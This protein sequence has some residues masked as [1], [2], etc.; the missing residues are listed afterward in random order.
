MPLIVEGEILGVLDVQSTEIGAFGPDD[1]FILETLADQVAVAVSS[2]RAYE[3]Q[4]E[5]AWVTTVMLQVAEAT[6]RAE[7]MADALDATVRVTAMLAG[8]ASCIIWLWNEERAAFEYGASYG[9]RFEQ[10]ED[11]ATALRLLPGEWSALD[12]LRLEQKPAVMQRGDFRLPEP[13]HRIC[14]GDIVAL[15]PMLNRGETFGILGVSFNRELEARLTERRVTM[16]TGIAQ[17][18]AAAV[19]N[20]RL[21]AAREEEAWLST[22]LLQV[23]DILRIPQALGA[24][25]DQVAR[26][27]PALT[28]VDRCAILLRD[29]Q[30]DFRVRTVYATDETLAGVYAGLIL[31][32]GEL[33]L[34]DNA[35]RLGQP[36]VV[37]DVT[38]NPRIPADWQAR[39]GSRTLLVMPLIAADEPIGAM[40]VDDVC[41]THVF[42][43]RRVRILSGIAN[44][45]AV[46]I[47]NYR[48][49][50][51]EAERA[52]LA[53]ELELAH[54]I[55]SKLLP[56]GAPQPPGYEIAY[57]WRSA[58]EVG[59]DFF[60]FIPIAGGAVGLVVADVSDKGIPAALYMMFARTLLR[61]TAI[62]GRSPAVVLER[63][64]ELMLADSASDMFVTAY[65]SVLDPEKHRLTVASAGH[66]LAVYAPAGAGEP[67]PLITAG[68][69][70]GILT[71][72][73]IG[74]QQLELAP[75]DLVVFYTD[76]VSEAFSAGG[77]AFGDE[78]LMALV[79]EN[80]AMTASEIA[81]AIAEAV[82]AFI[83]DETQ[84]DDIT[85][86]VLKRDELSPTG[87]SHAD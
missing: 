48:L 13:L 5:E 61:A 52:S 28:G 85:L 35:C 11:P 72:A 56:Q 37:D 82:Q 15:I 87:V 14:A 81:A 21:A 12:R 20:T 16:L 79:K 19:D 40:L 70:L 39:F 10:K 27:V 23:S 84:S 62:S 4:R 9:L 26:L 36:L 63:A 51:R 69:P 55:Q 1:R 76:G 78:R 83:G 29:A 64:N 38:N 31:A 8:A 6:A 33:E 65:Y 71:P 58:R 45:A 44:Q 18:A 75:G 42:S 74:E 22:L 25:L 54:G 80:R 24:T 59:G 49:Q 67:I 66:N 3:A 60:D 32:P 77:E 34:L 53:R 57:R 47:E 2:A 50:E 7:S 86:I 43:P 30:G 68:I 41:N 17:Q 73:G 46:A